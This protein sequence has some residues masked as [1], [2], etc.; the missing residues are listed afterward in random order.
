MKW[1]E[2]AHNSAINPDAIYE[3]VAKRRE[4]SGRTCARAS[5]RAGKGGVDKAGNSILVRRLAC[6]PQTEAAQV[7]DIATQLCSICTFCQE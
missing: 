6:R 7:M 5:D 2:L 3:H 1:A 4:R